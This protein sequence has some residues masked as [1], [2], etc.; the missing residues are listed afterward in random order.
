[1]TKKPSK[2][3]RKT[4]TRPPARN[5]LATPGGQ[6]LDPAVRAV[7]KAAAIKH[8]E[9]E[10]VTFRLPV[11]LTERLRQIAVKE[12][13]SQKALSDVA[14]VM[15]E[16]AVAQYDAGQLHFKKEPVVFRQR[17]ARGQ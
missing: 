3:T 17:L 15:I 11:E 10:K 7:I 13:G 9:V 4:T 6:D 2:P 16:E 5:P 14:C 1:M 8:G 12:G